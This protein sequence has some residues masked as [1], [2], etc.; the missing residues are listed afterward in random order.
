MIRFGDERVGELITWY[1][2]TLQKAIGAIWENLAWRYDFKNYRRGRHTKVRVP[3][4]PKSR[5]FK[6]SLRDELERENPYA[7]HRVNAVIRTAYS[8]MNSWRKRYVKGKAKK[9]TVVRRRFARCKTTLMKADYNRKV[10][11]ITLRPGE[12]VEISYAGQWFSKRVE[13]GGSGEVVLK[14]DRVIIPFKREDL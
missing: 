2:A 14:D 10:I 9:K 5:K 6:K 1:R 8:F 12:C 11:R 4:I 3:L 7:S 13:G